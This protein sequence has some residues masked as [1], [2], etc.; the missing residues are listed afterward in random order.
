MNEVLNPFYKG[1][2]IRANEEI[3]KYNSKATAETY[4]ADKRDAL[5]KGLGLPEEVMN[6]PF[7][8]TIGDRVVDVQG[9]PYRGA[10]VGVG[11]T[12]ATGALL[13]A[14]SQQL[15]EGQDTGVLPTV[16]RATRNLAEGTS[17]LMGGTL[18]MDPLATARNNLTEAGQTL[19][20]TRMLEALTLDE[21]DSMDSS[22][23]GANGESIDV[24]T[25]V[26]ETAKNL[27]N[28]S[29]EDSS[30]NVRPYSPEKALSDARNIVEMELRASGSF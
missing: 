2:N 9:L 1:E 13:N 3:G 11:S 23:T 28:Y 8:Q 18:G 29:V 16:G 12:L 4:L 17:A 19:G 21:I 7:A 6:N 14:Y 24:E 30:G 5:M 15:D 26:L 25:M 20:S 27:M 10:A 22:M